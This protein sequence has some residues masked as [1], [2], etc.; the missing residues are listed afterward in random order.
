MFQFQPKYRLILGLTS[1]N[2]QFG[3]LQT[4]NITLCGI[5]LTEI[6]CQNTPEEK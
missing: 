3:D 6:H 1:S 2:Y 4:A 5:F